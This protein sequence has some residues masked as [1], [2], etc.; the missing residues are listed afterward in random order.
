MYFTAID[1]ETTG[2]VPGFDNEAWQIGLYIVH[3]DGRTQSYS[4]YLKTDP[5]RPFNP[6]APG[7][8]M[9]I[10]D[11]LAASPTLTELWEEISAYLVSAP[12]VAHNIGTERTILRKAFP[13]NKPKC[14]IDTLKL[15][16]LLYP[17]LDNYALETLIAYFGLTDKIN[18]IAP[19]L[20]PHDALYD[21]V[22]AG[23]L[24]RFYQSAPILQGLPLSTIAT[25][26]V[27][28]IRRSGAAQ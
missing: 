27:A 13:L 7:R 25:L 12:L 28:G 10:R 6:H 20:S 1:F 15:S 23:E 26:R 4:S 22:A 19:G 21:A 16:K 9:L 18:A 11:E 24:L 5:L 14:W 17:K 2:S 3:A 8:H